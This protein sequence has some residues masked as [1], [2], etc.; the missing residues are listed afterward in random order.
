MKM[1]I[2]VVLA[3]AAF[4]GSAGACEGS[5]D[6]WSRSL[7]ALRSVRGHFDGGAWTASVDQWN[8]AKHRTMQCLARHAVAQA[9]TPAQLLEWMGPPDERVRCPSEAC[10]AFAPALQG[11]AEAWLYRWRANHDRLGFALVNGRVGRA[12]WFYAGE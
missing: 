12:Q 4:C 8:G 1:V 9:A 2:F 7:S 5:V 6:D 3:T 10:S 11:P